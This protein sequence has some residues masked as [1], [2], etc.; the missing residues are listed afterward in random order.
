ME[1]KKNLPII[2]VLIVSIALNV[3]LILLMVLFPVFGFNI[4]KNLPSEFSTMSE[5][6]LIINQDYIDK[7][8]L[9]PKKISEGAVGGMVTALDDKYSAYLDPDTRVLEMSTFKGK[10]YGIGAYVGSKNNQLVII[11]PIEGSPAEEAGLLPGD[12]II[13]INDE[14][15]LGL[16]VTEAALKIQGPEGTDVKLTVLREDD[17]QP[18]DVTITR[19]E[20]VLKSVFWEIKDN[21]MYIKLIGFAENT[22]PELV[23]A[24]NQSK[25]QN[26]DGVVLDLRNNGG[27]LLNIAVDVTSQFLEKGVVVRAVN[28]RGEESVEP[29]IAGGLAIDIPLVILVNEGSASASEVVAG[30]LQD[31]DRAKLFGKTTFGKGSVQIVRSLS[32][33]SAIHITTARWLTPNGRTID[34]IG[35]QPDLYSELEGDELVDFAIDYLTGEIK[36]NP[37]YE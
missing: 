26:V 36:L 19:Q 23:D 25:L 1:E 35:L 16:S 17:E 18:F 15:T 27:G 14:D 3:C 13:K 11:A 20:I 34:D 2:I 6:W 12:M 33:G 31:Y 22:T 29:V 37:S 28:N 5:A 21:V 4:S 7:D 32:D 24:L 9:N 10:F 30:A 8:E